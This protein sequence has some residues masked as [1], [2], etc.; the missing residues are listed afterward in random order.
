MMVPKVEGFI[1]NP[2]SYIS[3]FKTIVA[4]I[5]LYYLII[6]NTEIVTNKIINRIYYNLKSLLKISHLKVHKIIKYREK[7]HKKY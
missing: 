7:V 2:I 1:R 4:I 3:V 6:N 5:F